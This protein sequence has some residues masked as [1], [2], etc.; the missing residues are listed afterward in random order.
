[1]SITEDNEANVTFTLHNESGEV[2][3]SILEAGTRE[4]NFTNLDDGTYYYNVSVY[5]AAGNY[6][7]TNTKEITLDDTIPNGTLLTPG[8]GTYTNETSQNLT[9]NASDNIGLDNATLF[10]Y[11]SSSDLIN[12]TDVEVSGTEAV[13]G[14]VY[15]FLY[16]G[17]F[18]WFYR[19]FDVAGNEFQTENN[20]I[21]I[22]TVNPGIEFGEGTEE[23]ETNFT[24]DWIYVNVSVVEVNE[25][26]ITFRLHNEI[27]EVNVSTFSTSVR[28]INFTGLV[29]GYYN[30]NVTLVD[31]ANNRNTTENRFIRIDNT[32]PEITIHHPEMK[33][34]GVNTS[35]P[36]NVS[37]LDAVVGVE[38]CWWNIDNNANETVACNSNVT[39][40]VTEGDKS[41]TLHYYSNDSLGNLGYSN[42]TFG[43]STAGPAITLNSPEDDTYYNATD[44]IVQF[45]YTPGDPDG[46][47]TCFLYGNWSGGW[48][49]NQTDSEIEGEE[50]NSFNVSVESD[51]EGHYIW[52]VE[53]NDSLNL[54][55]FALENY[56]F[57]ID[58]T[59]PLI[60]F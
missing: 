8:N 2:N 18:E 47:D 10:V 50:I 59:N 38:S 37:V 4:I 3:V 55:S 31:Y 5:D 23:S 20:T 21:I 24:R 26:N 32:G 9:V 27:G 16:D 58:I 53:C 52:N 42:V 49:I 25:A 33:T 48:H 57:S 22:D 60:D 44:V 43:V 1:V 29:D 51:G 15:E 6:N 17:I 34:Y 35:L 19:I 30:Y 13:I 56:T 39:F 36:L 41:Y 11:N 7:I 45:N 54:F 28:D 14:V 40:N 46:V 12:Q